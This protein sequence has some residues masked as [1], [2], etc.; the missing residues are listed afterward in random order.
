M[1]AK[2]WVFGPNLNF[3]PERRISMLSAD[4]S[5]ATAP[6][7][8]SPPLS[9]LQTNS[10]SPQQQILGNAKIAADFGLKVI[11]RGQIRCLKR[12]STCTG[13]PMT[14][15][16]SVMSVKPVQGYTGRVDMRK[17]T[18]TQALFTKSTPPGCLGERK[19]F[20]KQDPS[21]TTHPLMEAP[22][23]RGRSQAGMPQT[24]EPPVQKDHLNPQ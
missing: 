22:S 11:R 15:H 2:N 1:A 20:G 4:A 14:E 9:K 6:P 8:S 13:F 16:F 12:Y 17:D 7:V 3:S 21:A 10:N 5:S 23:S 19:N 24:P 18:P